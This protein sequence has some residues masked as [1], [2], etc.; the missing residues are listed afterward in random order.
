MPF[1][2]SQETRAATLAASSAPKPQRARS[3]ARQRLPIEPGGAWVVGLGLDAGARVLDAQPVARVGGLP[4]LQL[5]EQVGRNPPAPVRQAGDQA[6][7]FEPLEPAN[8]P[9]HEVGGWGG[10]LR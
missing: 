9:R 3:G 4:R 8:V 7:A 10:L 1:E 5:V 2:R 6:V